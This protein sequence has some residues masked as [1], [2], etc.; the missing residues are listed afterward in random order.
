MDQTAIDQQAANRCVSGSAY[1]AGWGFSIFQLSIS[2]ERT[3]QELTNSAVGNVEELNSTL[4]NKLNNKVK[5]VDYYSET[6][7]KDLLL[8][9]TKPY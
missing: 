4:Q 7:D 8:G 3:G 1:F 9:K 5:A 2:L 6:I